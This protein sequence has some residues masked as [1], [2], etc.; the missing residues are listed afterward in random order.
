MDAVIENLQFLKPLKVSNLNITDEDAQL[1]L[2]SKFVVKILCCYNPNPQVVIGFS[3]LSRL[4]KTHI[5][6]SD[7]WVSMEFDTCIEMMK[8]GSFMLLHE[9]IEGAYVFQAKL[10]GTIIPSI[11]NYRQFFITEK[12]FSIFS[13]ILLEKIVCQNSRWK[14][15]KK[16]R[17]MI[18][19][20]ELYK[21]K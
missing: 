6:I 15:C 19:K 16:T 5:G 7:G 18:N 9:P 14:V 13:D 20:T 8:F 10:G 12:L 21:I 1:K 3:E 2:S 17:K 4:L 11:G